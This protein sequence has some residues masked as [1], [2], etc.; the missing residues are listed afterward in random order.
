MRIA[1]AVAEAAMAS[2]VAT[3]PIADLDAYRAQLQN[4]VYHS[5]VV[6]KPVFTVARTLPSQ[7]KRVI[8]WMARCLPIR[9]SPQRCASG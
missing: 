9:P 4:F 7:Q 6:M 5:G 1:P 3:R 8:T 2:G